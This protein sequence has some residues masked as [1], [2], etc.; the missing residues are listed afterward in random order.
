MKAKNDCKKYALTGSDI[1]LIGKNLRN[2][3]NKRQAGGVRSM[4][5]GM[6]CV[7]LNDMCIV[8]QDNCCIQIPSR[9]LFVFKIVGLMSSIGTVEALI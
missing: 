2:L 5:L 7:L 4:F 8:Q 1:G 9:Q 3:R 6:T